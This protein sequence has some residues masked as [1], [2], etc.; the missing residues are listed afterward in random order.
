MEGRNY[1][2]TIILS[3]MREKIG[4]TEIGLQSLQPAGCDT[5]RIGVTMAVRHVFGICF[6]L[7]L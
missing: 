4:V 7:M 1:Q 2:L 5:L 6:T 3:V